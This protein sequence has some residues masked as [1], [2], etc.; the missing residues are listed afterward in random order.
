[1]SPL[2]IASGLGVSI[3]VCTRILP[4][5]IMLIKPQDCGLPRHHFS[6][7]VKAAMCCVQWL[8]SKDYLVSIGNVRHCNTLCI[9][10]V[11]VEQNVETT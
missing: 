7:K 10:T 6:V 4:I 2:A 9:E 3:P 11:I 1:M 5:W 8:G